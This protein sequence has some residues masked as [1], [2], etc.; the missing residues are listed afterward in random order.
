MSRALRSNLPLLVM[1]A[2]VLMAFVAL[3]ATFVEGGGLWSRVL[4]ILLHPLCVAGLLA[5]AP[6][7]QLSRTA[8]LAIAGL[9]AP[10]F[11]LRHIPRGAHCQRVCGWELVVPCRVRLDPRSGDRLRA[12]T[13][14]DASEAAFPLTPAGGLRDLR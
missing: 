9:Q 1:S 12:E 7:P 6:T 13:C 10:H 2:A 5:L 4:L 3:V 14:R 8:V 11:G